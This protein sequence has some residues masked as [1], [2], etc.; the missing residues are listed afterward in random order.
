MRPA[1]DVRVNAG[2]HAIFAEDL[3]ERSFARC[4]KKAFER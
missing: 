2:A 1:D 3:V 4:L